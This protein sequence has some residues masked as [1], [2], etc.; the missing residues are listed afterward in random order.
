MK[1]TRLLDILLQ[2]KPTGQRNLSRRKLG[3]MIPIEIGT[4]QMAEAFKR[5]Q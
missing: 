1:E 2:Y 4:H 3:L 5:M